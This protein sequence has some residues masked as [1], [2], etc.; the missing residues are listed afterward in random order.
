MDISQNLFGS[1]AIFD[2]IHMESVCVCVEGCV[3]NFIEIL[4]G[5]ALHLLINL[6]RM[7]I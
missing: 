1:Y 4:I 3:K 5:I 2:Q 7:V 6:S